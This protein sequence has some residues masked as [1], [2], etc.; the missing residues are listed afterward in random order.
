MSTADDKDPAML[1]YG[2]DFY[3]DEAVRLMTL[4]Q[5]A[6]YMR[7]LWHAW[8][9]GSI[10]ADVDEIGAIVAK[11]SPRRFPLVWER[12]AVKWVP[13]PVPGRLVNKRLE[14]ER[15]K[16]L[17]MRRRQSDAGKKGS[18]SRWGRHAGAN[19][20]A[21]PPPEPGSGNGIASQSKSYPNPSVPSGPL[22]ESVPSLCTGQAER[23]QDDSP[24]RS[25]SEGS[26]GTRLFEALRQ[27]SYR[28]NSPTRDLDLLDASKRL[29]DA[30]LDDADLLKLA[31]RAQRKGN[32]PQ[33]LFAHW[34]DHVDEA[35]KELGKR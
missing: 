27:S 8:R 18:E 5:E 7:L 9:E 2:R 11:V 33:G 24:S 13:G 12:I 34:V 10:P 26:R 6:A 32:R 1:L 21:M 15:Q 16:R 23:Q 31:K 19:G 25:G 3:E 22:E 29:D 20:V 35:L 30:N 17:E 28:A 14:V 4:E